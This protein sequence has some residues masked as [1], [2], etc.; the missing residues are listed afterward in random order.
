LVALLATDRMRETPEEKAS[1][2]Q[3][4]KL[5]SDRDRRIRRLKRRLEKDPDNSSIRDEIELHRH[6]RQC[7]ARHV[8]D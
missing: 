1:W 7:I 5:K 8:P 2:D 6:I 4:V 3:G